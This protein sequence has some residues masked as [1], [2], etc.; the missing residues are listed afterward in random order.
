[1]AQK[2]KNPKKPFFGLGGSPMKFLAKIAYH[3]G[4]ACFTIGKFLKKSIFDP[5]FT[6]WAP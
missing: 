6:A 4:R 2:V 1:M 3:R 5:I